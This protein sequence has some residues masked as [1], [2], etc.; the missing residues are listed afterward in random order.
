MVIKIEESPVEAQQERDTEEVYLL[1][2][3]PIPFTYPKMGRIVNIHRR[4]KG[5]PK[6]QAEAA[7][8]D[9]IMDWLERGFGPAVW[10]YIQK[11]IDNEDDRLDTK[12]LV[13]AFTQLV[14]AHAGRPTTS[15][16]D[17]SPQPWMKSQTGEPSAEESESETWTPENSAT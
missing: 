7:M 17:A 15:S 9:T 14:E 11:R 10:D 1:G 12:H 8:G 4:I 3:G 13:N 16:S 2:E 5:M 6:A